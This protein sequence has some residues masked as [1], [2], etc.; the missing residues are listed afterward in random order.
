MDFSAKDWLTLAVAIL[1]AVISILNV[2]FNSWSQSKLENQKWVQARQDDA[3]KN[4]RM[5]IIEMAR[6][7]AT[8]NQLV[9]FLTWKAKFEP[10]NLSTTDIDGY[11]AGMKV[12]LPDLMTSELTVAAMDKDT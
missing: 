11:D 3:N 5:A 1:A 7:L 4:L 9:Q 2:I 10:K 12:L 6:K 8:A